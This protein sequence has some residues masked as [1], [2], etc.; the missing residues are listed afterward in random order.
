MLIA[1]SEV[2]CWRRIG[3]VVITLILEVKWIFTTQQCRIG[4]NTIFRSVRRIGR[5]LAESRASALMT[6]PLI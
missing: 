6:N 4:M 5:V 3:I 1:R 2:F